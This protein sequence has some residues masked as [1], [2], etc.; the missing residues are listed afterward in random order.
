MLLTFVVL[1]FVCCV[2]FR[3][4]EN[5]NRYWRRSVCGF[6]KGLECFLGKRNNVFASPM[7]SVRFVAFV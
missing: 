1:L 2:C 3:L 7:N 5:I 4:S 6:S